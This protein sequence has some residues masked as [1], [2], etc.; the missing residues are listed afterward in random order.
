[1]Y[2]RLPQSG[3]FRNGAAA[4]NTSILKVLAHFKR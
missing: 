3:F 2:L 4:D 1:V